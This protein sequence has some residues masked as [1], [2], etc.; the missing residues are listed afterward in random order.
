VKPR[1]GL[2]DDAG[3]YDYFA[4]SIAAGEGYQMPW[5]TPTAFWPIGYPAVLSA[6]YFVFGPGLTAARLLNCILGALTAGSTY[7]FGRRWFSPGRAAGGG[8]VL[9]FMPGSIGFVNLTLSETLFTLL[10]VVAVLML[11][12]A[13]SQGRRLPFVAAFGAVLAAA[14]LVRGQAALIPVIAVPWLLLQGWRPRRALAFGGVTLAVAAVLCLPWAVR[15]SLTFHTPLLLST[16]LGVN[17]WSGHHAGA[18]GGLQFEHQVEFAG[19]F[20]DLDPLAQEPAEDRQGLKDA[21]DFATGHPGAEASLSAKKIARLFRDDSDA[22]RWNEHNGDAPIFSART[23]STLTTIFDGYYYVCAA[24]AL[25]FLGNGLLQRK[26]WAHI[27]VL[28]VI[29]WTAVHVVF[30]AEPRFH[31]P[32]LP[33]VALLAGSAV[34]SALTSARERLR[35]VQGGVADAAGRAVLENPNAKM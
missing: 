4:R 1:P 5:G 18:N 25:A 28:I 2:F 35:V 17:L 3:Y 21:I 12:I 31:A 22:V 16:N 6:V 9:A 10:F 20:D 27:L 11:A 7:F 24:L 15:N 19:R 8:I 33:F 14:T 34:V 29:Y 30:F 23:K 26:G 13:P 32:L